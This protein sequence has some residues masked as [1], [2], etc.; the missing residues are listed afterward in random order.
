MWPQVAM[1]PF[2]IAVIIS[3]RRVGVGLAGELLGEV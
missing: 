3:V 2:L 1:E